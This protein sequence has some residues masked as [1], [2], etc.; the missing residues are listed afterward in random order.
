[1]PA[2]GVPRRP[3]LIFDFGNVVAYFDYARACAKVAPEVGL[4]TFELLTRARGAGL[5]GLV[6]EFERGEIEDRAFVRRFGALL[7]I[8]LDPSAFAA[9][10]ADIF[11]LNEAV[12]GVV[13]ELDERGHTLVL[14]SNTNAIHS[15]HFRNAF[16]DTMGRFDACVLSHEIGWLKPSREFFLAC[17]RAA[18]ASPQDCVFV[19]DLEENVAGA[20]AAGMAAIQYFSTPVLIEELRL[21]GVD[22]ERGRAENARHKENRES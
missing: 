8:E 11:W 14:G 1:M 21:H 22:L 18:G 5:A 20:R 15:R 4:S 3:A 9:A 6:E 7:D 2:I 12:A 13:A 16:A 10:W 17:A 19:D